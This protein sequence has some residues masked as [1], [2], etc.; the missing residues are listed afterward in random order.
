MIKEKQFNL[1]LRKPDKDDV[2]LATG[3]HKFIEAERLDQIFKNQIPSENLVI[4]EISDKVS[5]GGEIEITFKSLLGLA[6]C[7]VGVILIKG[8]YGK[9]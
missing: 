1:I 7:V 4:E 2:I 3:S 5:D 8:L 9:K 6:F